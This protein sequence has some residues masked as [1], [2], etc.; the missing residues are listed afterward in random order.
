[1]SRIRVRVA[2]VVVGGFLAALPAVAQEATSQIR[3]RVTDQ[4]AGA[5]PGV[6][7]TVTNQDSGNFRGGERC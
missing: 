2:A 7:V 1:M 4:Q 3:G 6:T 5:L